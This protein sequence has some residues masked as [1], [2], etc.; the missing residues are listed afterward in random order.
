MW[1]FI[2][3][4]SSFSAQVLTILAQEKFYQVDGDILF[5]EFLYPKSW[6]DTRVILL[7]IVRSGQGTR[8][9]IYNWEGEELLLGEPPICT[10]TGLLPSL[11]FPTMVIPLAKESAYLLVGTKSMA[12]YTPSSESPPM[13]YPPILPDGDSLQAGL[14]TRWAR[15]SRNWMYSQRYDGIFLC[16]ENGWIYY[17]EFGNDNELETQT[18]LGQLP[19]AVDT[20]FDI[21]DMGHEGGDF[22]IAAGSQGDGGLFVQ[23]ARDHPRCVQRFVNWAPVPDAVIIP[24][25]GPTVSDRSPADAQDRL[26]VCSPSASGNGAITELRHGVEA[27]IG[28]SAEMSGIHSIRDMW[29]VASYFDDSIYLMVSDPLSSYLLHT[30]LDMRNGISALEDGT[31]VENEETLATGCTPLGVI[32]QVTGH[33]VRLSTPD[34]SSHAKFIRHDPLMTVTAAVVDGPSS[35]V[36]MTSRSQGL[37]YLHIHRIVTTINGHSL[38]DDEA[39][40]PLHKEPICISFNSCDQV[41][42]IFLGTG[43][44]TVLSFELSGH[45]GGLRRHAD[46]SVPDL[47]SADKS[48]A[49]DSLTVVDALWED[50]VHK[51]LLCGLR[52]GIL[53]SFKIDTLVANFSDIPVLAINGEQCLLLLRFTFADQI[54]FLKVCNNKSR[55]M[56]G[57]HQSKSNHMEHTLCL[58][59]VISYGI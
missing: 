8:S 49:I 56:L 34:D 43:D 21:L 22:I 37:Y 31:G 50:R 54:H 47:H 16:Q 3:T 20:A 52:S 29:A 46:T 57:K 28:V 5:M 59:A 19:C 6:T 30:T 11:Q 48:R 53:V 1:S 9:V 51:F 25:N 24:A 44:G 12:L 17:L 40:Y 42:F 7:M 58:L 10:S 2:T 33:G 4:C 41:E 14:W 18:S 15:P 26:F 23:E 32:V 27:L 38:S 55:G 45:I 36:V 39:P 13:R 35:A